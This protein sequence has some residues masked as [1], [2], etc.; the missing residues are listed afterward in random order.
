MCDFPNY[1]YVGLSEAIE[2]YEGVGGDDS[3]FLLWTVLL[4]A[5]RDSIQLVRA[6]IEIKAQQQRLKVIS[7]LLCSSG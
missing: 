6:L 1:R 4:L 5:I 7:S 3:D 2:P